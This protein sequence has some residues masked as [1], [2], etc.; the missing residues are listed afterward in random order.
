[1]PLWGVS[2]DRAVADSFGARFLFVLDGRFHGVAAWRHGEQSEQ[3]EI[4]TGGRY[5]VSD[6]RHQ[7]GSTVATLIEVAEIAAPRSGGGGQPSGGPG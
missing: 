4:I 2:L 3:L 7:D 6:L 5:R 1:M